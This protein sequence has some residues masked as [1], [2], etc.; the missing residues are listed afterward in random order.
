MQHAEYDNCHGHDERKFVHY[1]LMGKSI[2]H[3]K[4]NRRIS[5]RMVLEGLEGVLVII[6][7]YL[8]FFLSPLRAR[9]GLKR[10]QLEREFPGDDLVPVPKAS[11]THGIEI[12]APITQVWPWIAQIGKDKGGF[13]SY[14]ALENLAGLQ[15]YNANKILPEFQ[16]PKIGDLMAFGPKDAYPIVICDPPHTLCIENW[17]DME[18]KKM[19]DPQDY[20]PENYMHLSWCWYLESLEN[21][22]TRL[23]SRNRVTYNDSWKAKLMGTFSEPLVFAMDRK[24][25]LGIKHRAENCS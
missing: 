14:E 5:P 16:N 11:F 21:H 17:Y 19:Y 7:C 10:E 6:L 2:A 15:I 3:T 25:C 4:N 24:M 22:H 12:K 23:Y 8:T 18:A 20:S 9:W 13:Y 1:I